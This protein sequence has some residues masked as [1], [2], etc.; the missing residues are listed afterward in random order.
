MYKTEQNVTIQS[1]S[2]WWASTLR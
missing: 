1:I 2:V